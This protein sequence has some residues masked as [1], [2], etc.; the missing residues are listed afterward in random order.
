MKL[1]TNSLA[2]FLLLRVSPSFHRMVCKICNFSANQIRDRVDYKENCSGHGRPLVGKCR[3]DRLYHGPRCEIK[4]ECV[5][6]TDCGILGT[7]VDHGGTT[8]PTKQ[9]YCDAGWFGPGCAKS[10]NFPSRISCISCDNRF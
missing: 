9:C 4:E 10:K 5:D 7:C 1:M 3:C 6:D 8:V 2:K